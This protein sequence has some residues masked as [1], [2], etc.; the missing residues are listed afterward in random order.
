[1]GDAY[2]DNHIL[3]EGENRQ[4]HSQDE[5]QQWTET[6]THLLIVETIRGQVSSKFARELTVTYF[7]ARALAH[8]I[9]AIH[10]L[11]ELLHTF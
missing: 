11:L 1:M 10:Q 8:E 5:G 3:S 9:Q 7:L 6:F 2:Q 4:Q